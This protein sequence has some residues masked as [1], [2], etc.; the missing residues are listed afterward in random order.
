MRCEWRLE[1]ETL[2]KI[3][4]IFDC[5]NDQNRHLLLPHTTAFKSQ[6]FLLCKYYLLIISGQ[7]SLSETAENIIKSYSKLCNLIFRNSSMDENTLK[8]SSSFCFFL[9]IYFFLVERGV[10]GKYV[11]Q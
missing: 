10:H 4:C 8:R 1:R 9:A 6:K 11:F 7:Q 5:E 2:I 3:N